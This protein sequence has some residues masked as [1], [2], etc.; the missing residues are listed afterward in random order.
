MKLETS[1]ASKIKI[2]YFFAGGAVGLA[3][4]ELVMMLTRMM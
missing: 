2:V 4:I 3:V 1:F